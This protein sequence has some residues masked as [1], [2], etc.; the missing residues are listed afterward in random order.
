MNASSIPRAAHEAVHDVAPWIER[1]ARM[2]FVA[3]ALLY[4]TIGALAAGAALGVGRGKTT[5]QRGAM[6]ELIQSPFGHVVIALIASGLAGY[7]VWRIIE[8]IVDPEHRG[9]GAKGIA[10]RVKSLATG[11]IHAGLAISATRLVLGRGVGQSSS[12]KSEDWT[13]K[14]LSTDGGKIAVGL[15][16]AAFIGYGLYQLYCAIKAKLSKQL[17]LGR[18]GPTARNAVIAA[19]RFG[20]ASRGIVFGMAGVLFLR[21]ALHQNPKEAGSVPKSLGTLFELGFWPY[22]AITVGLIAYGVYQL[23]N[24]RY[25]RIDVR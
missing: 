20:I 1:L 9:H 18:L 16:A 14:A 4:M 2:G 8:G 23:I 11:L 17:S 13:A 19:S 6:V 12:R 25:R 10:L 21:A 5:D 22:I 3:K 15:V 24:A 7:A